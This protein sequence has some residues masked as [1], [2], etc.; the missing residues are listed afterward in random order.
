MTTA[1]KSVNG[2]FITKVESKDLKD[3]PAYDADGWAKER[4]RLEE[5]TRRMIYMDSGVNPRHNPN[6]T[7][8][9]IF[10]DVE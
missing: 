7:S 10:R 1:Y 3:T 5:T 9:E 2:K 4:A 6:A 8:A